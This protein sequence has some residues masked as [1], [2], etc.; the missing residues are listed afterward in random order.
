[1]RADVSCDL[2]TKPQLI[3]RGG[4]KATAM[5]RP[6]VWDTEGDMSFLGR[7]FEQDVL[8][9][10]AR[11]TLVAIFLVACAGST[12]PPPAP[13]PPRP[14]ESIDQR[15][16]RGAGDACTV[17]AEIV[18][19]TANDEAAATTLADKACTLHAPS[20]CVIGGM[21]ARASRTCRVR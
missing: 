10:A 17:L 15:C 6:C 18:V 7:W 19:L 1:M 20:G 14:P 2:A 3:Q 5:T 4:C 16:E 12:P 9:R 13:R 21:I 8:R 11:F